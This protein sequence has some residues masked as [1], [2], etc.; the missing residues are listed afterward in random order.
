MPRSEGNWQH[1]LAEVVDGHRRASHQHPPGH[2][3]DN[4]QAARE[5]SIGTL[6]EVLLMVS[7]T[8]RGVSARR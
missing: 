4:G 7:S 1:P 8:Q 3:G 2:V 6:T 5:A